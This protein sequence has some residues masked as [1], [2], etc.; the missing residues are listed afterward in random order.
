MGA[1][2]LAAF[3]SR[4]GR[5]KVFVLFAGAVMRMGASSPIGSMNFV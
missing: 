1:A 2:W 3:I 5:R 4:G